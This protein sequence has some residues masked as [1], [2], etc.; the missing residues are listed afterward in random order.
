MYRAR[1]VIFRTEERVAMS[2]YGG[3]IDA[4]PRARAGGD[5]RRA[6]GKSNE[7]T[8]AA[9]AGR[10][11]ATLPRPAPGTRHAGSPMPFH[12]KRTILHTKS[13]KPRN[14][15]IYTLKHWNTELKVLS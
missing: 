10:R 9:G 7:A 4:G 5:P 3:A 11:R 6:R 8:R 2:W 13:R 1:R 15:V 12:K 14:L